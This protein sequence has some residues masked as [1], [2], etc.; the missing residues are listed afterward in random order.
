[1]QKKKKITA[2]QVVDFCLVRPLKRPSPPPKSLED[3]L[4]KIEKQLKKLIIQFKNHSHC[5]QDGGLN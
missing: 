4:T 5:M 3:R 2:K 1:M